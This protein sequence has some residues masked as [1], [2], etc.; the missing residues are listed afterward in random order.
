MIKVET[1]ITAAVNQIGHGLEELLCQGLLVLMAKSGYK[2]SSNACDED[3]YRH[4]IVFSSG[5]NSGEIYTERG[6][7]IYIRGE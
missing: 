4:K 6:M 2:T 5:N 3:G 1:V 7:I